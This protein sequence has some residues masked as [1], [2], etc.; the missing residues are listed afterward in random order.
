MKRL[1]VLVL[2][3]SAI[4]FPLSATAS[5]LPT[6][7]RGQVVYVP[8]TWQNIHTTGQ[9]SAS[10]LVVR[11]LDQANLILVKSVV[12]LD[13]DG[14][15]VKNLLDGLNCAGDPSGGP[16]SITLNPMQTTS[17]VTRLSTVC[18][19]QFPLDG[20]RP[21]WLVDWEAADGKGATPPRIT[22]TEDILTPTAIYGHG[23]V[24]VIIDSDS[25]VPGTVL[26]EK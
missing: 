3:L 12:F 26:V 13:P 9:T 22:A 20:G 24:G 11:N 1:L 4:A 7:S 6:Q 14:Q 17:F 18:V 19:P 16:T 10:R 15:F 2:T 25:V 23:G 8:A 21:A 5:D